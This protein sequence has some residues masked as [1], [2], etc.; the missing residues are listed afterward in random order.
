MEASVVQLRYQMRDVLRALSRN[1][2]VKILY[3]G[4][5]KGIIIP[6]RS[7][8]GMRMN[9][10]PFVGMKRRVRRPVSEQ[11]NRLRALRYHAL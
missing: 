5:I 4:E 10:H 2:R 6:F 7:A 8:S 1:E 3:H 9:D 11:V